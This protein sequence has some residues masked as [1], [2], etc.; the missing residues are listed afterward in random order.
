MA[1][2]LSDFFYGKII[3]GERYYT[4]HGEKRKNWRS[5]NCAEANYA[6]NC[7]HRGR[8]F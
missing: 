2:I 8:I 5:W 1:K 3:P 4:N 6:G 7:L